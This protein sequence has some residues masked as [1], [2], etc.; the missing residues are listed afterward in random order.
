MRSDVLII[1]AGPA[2]LFAAREI[3]TNSELRVLVI[4][5]GNDIDQRVC[6]I[7]EYKVCT[8][9]SPC[10]IL[11]G[12]GGAGT[13]SSGL[14]NLRPDIGGNLIELLGSKKRA[15]D[16]V[17]YVDSVL[18]DYGAPDKLHKPKGTR[19]RGVERKAASEGIRFIPI[20]QRMI[21]TDNASNVIKNFEQD[22][23]RRGVR[24]LFG[25]R[26]EKISKGRARLMDET[27]VKCKYVIAAPGRVGAQWLAQEARS[28]GIP[29]QYN[30]IDVGVRVEVPAIIME[31][32]C[33]ISL[34]PKFHVRTRTYDDF[35]RTFCANH[36]GFVV[37]E[38]Y[39]G[40]VGVNGHTLARK[41]SAN[42]N[43]ALLVRIEL[44][45]PLE[46]TTLYGQTVATQLTTLGGGK[47]LIQRLGDLRGG[48]RSTWNRVKRG[49]IVPT[50]K[51]VTPGDIAMGMPH[52]IVTD[53]MESLEKL[54]KVI[55]GVAA[56]STLLYAPEVKFS[57]SRVIVKGNLETPIE[58]LF[59]AGDG[60]GLSGGLVPAAASGVVAAR[61]ILQKE[62]ES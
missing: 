39:D 18:L 12:A 8:K 17:K 6:P 29:T 24:F 21:G 45:H 56:S 36:H 51:S 11:C 14:L 35:V 7:E 58:D 59:V 43:F 4:D 61:G 19:A 33:E 37:Q 53:I 40:F 62:A 20:P 47:P 13:L 42:T 22:L 49:A 3:A 27:E 9:C 57:A 23:A 46:N 34:D 41:K 38:V 16:L 30:P 5:Q 60:A 32:I 44:T 26:V 48:R 25:K 28:L 1:G 10:N 50:M 2:G 55:S 15:W 52:R 54:D 31:P